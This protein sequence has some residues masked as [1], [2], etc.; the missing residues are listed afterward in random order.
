M[1]DYW[2]DVYGCQRVIAD[3]RAIVDE[4]NEFQWVASDLYMVDRNSYAA[5]E[6]QNTYR[7]AEK[8]DKKYYEFLDDKLTPTYDAVIKELNSCI[9][10]MEEAVNYYL[11]GDAAMAYEASGS[12]A[13]FPEYRS[14]DG[15]STDSI[16][17]PSGT[18]SGTPDSG[19]TPAP[20]T[21]YP[22]PNDPLGDEHYISNP[23]EIA[24]VGKG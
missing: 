3:L 4:S 20:T 7:D 22:D 24:R 6:S 21:S 11:S 9:N 13:D 18:S 8:L 16:P 5:E 14:G 15:R 17:T 19:P 12:T 10:A 2:I 1:T 23:Y